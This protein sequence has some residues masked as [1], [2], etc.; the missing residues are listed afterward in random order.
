MA[1]TRRRSGKQW[2]FVS[3]DWRTLILISVS[4]AAVTK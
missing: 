2:K 1:V 3:M 4:L